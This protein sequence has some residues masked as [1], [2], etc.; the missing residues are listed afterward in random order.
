MHSLVPPVKNLGSRGGGLEALFIG[1]AGHGRRRLDGAVG[2]QG[3]AGGGVGIGSSGAS[4][5]LGVGRFLGDPDSDRQG[6]C[7]RHF[8]RA[9]REK[10][11]ARLVGYAPD[12]GGHHGQGV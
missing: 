2:T 7:A 5:L 8:P 11:C 3:P 6:P 10:A 9:V 1:G 12:D 4:R